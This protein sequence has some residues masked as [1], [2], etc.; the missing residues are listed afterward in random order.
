MS[1]ETDGFE[2]YEFLLDTRE[3]MLFR[4]GKPVP[5]TPKAFQLLLTLVE[6]HGRLVE[7]EELM[8]A[9]WADSFVEEGNL[10][11]TIRLLRK[12]LGD[13][14]RKPRFIETVPRRGYRFIAEVRKPAEKTVSDDESESAIV[15]TTP[16]EKSSGASR[17]SKKIALTAFAVLAV[18]LIFAG[19]WYL[20]KR[21]SD[22][23]APVLSTTFSA[24]KLSTNGKV[25]HVVISPDGKNVVYTNVSSGRT[26]VWLRQLDSTNNVE[27]IPPLEDFYGKLALSPDG[28]FLYFSRRP[29][30]FDGQLDIYRVSIFGGVPTKIIAET[31][32]WLSLSPDGHRISF[33][34]CYYRKED[35]CS[36]WIADSADGKNERRLLSRPLPFRISDNKISPDGKSIAFAFGQSKN[37]GN[38]F[39]LAEV[40]IESG[41]EHELTAQK[42]FNINSIV[43]LPDRIGLLFTASGIPNR[44][45]RIWQVTVESG[46]VQP[47]TKDSETYAELSLSK[48]ASR[49]ISTQVNQDFSLSLFQTDDPSAR[50]VLANAWFARFAPNGKIFFSSIMSGNDEVWSIEPNGSGQR[51]L[52]ND[53][54]DDSSP[55][56]SPDDNSIF[57]VSNRTG[58]AH[59]WRMNADGSNPVQITHK[60]G[61]FPIF[62]S[63]DGRWI[64]YHH[65]I[66]RTLWRASTDGGDEQLV[67]DKGTSEF[68]LSPDGLQVAFPE[69]QGEE[70]LLTVVSL[71]DRQIIK[72]FNLEDPKARLVQLAWLSD[73]K[74]IGYVLADN[75][76]Q[77]N[78]LWVQ[79]FDGT[80]PRKIVDLGD[81]EIRSLTFAPDGKSFAAVQGGWRHDAV[82]F[83]GLK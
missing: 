68:E 60:E 16:E 82:L 54:A 83:K 21:G 39:S 74:G 53:A 51:Q 59:V 22:T 14:R 66:E 4:D 33:V 58:Q 49:L 32:G 23:S 38:E 78:S 81:E 52:T 8:K 29:R 41:A 6:N 44:H 2:F 17:S 80:A 9:V 19:F 57:F 34:R 7:K 24:E 72:T 37:A 12:A 69:R 5:I 25:F 31:Q 77:K 71:E 55:I 70:R 63:P 26:G 48:D 3:K 61:G 27:I 50:Q 56:V 20:I 15:E 79:R 65:G 75:D 11:F 36:L 62:V 47:L 67:F 43:W 28:N 10:T 64:Y 42:F 1:L 76:F 40:D 45:S 73:G 18:G 46:D 30:G 35:Y 13:Q